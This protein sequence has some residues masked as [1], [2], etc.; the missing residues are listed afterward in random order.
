MSGFHDLSIKSLEST[1]KLYRDALDSDTDRPCGSPR[2][3][4]TR[5]LTKAEDVLKQK[6]QATDDLIDS[7]MAEEVP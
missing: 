7:V 1:I 4:V 2:Y 6:Q 3:M 5:W